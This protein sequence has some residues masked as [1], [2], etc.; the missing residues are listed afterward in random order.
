MS[1]TIKY[2]KLDPISHIHKRPDMYIGSLKPRAQMREW[3]AEKDRIVEKNSVVYSDGLLRIFIEA[4]SNSIDNVW[5]SRQAGLRP[6]KIRVTIDPLTGETSLWNDGLH[7][8]VEM[9][10][11][12]KIYNPELIFGHLLSGSNLDD[13]EARLSSGRNGLGIKLLNVFSTEFHVECA[14]PI[15]RKI[16]RQSWYDNMRR[17][18]PPTL[19]AYSL[20]TGYTCIRWK[21]DLEKFEMPNRVYDETILSL[22]EKYCM[23]AAM[24]TGIAVSFNE[25]KF[26]FKNFLDYVRLYASPPSESTEDVVSTDTD[27]DPDP[28]APPSP[29]PPA[30]PVLHA[31]SF[32]SDSDGTDNAYKTQYVILESPTQEYKEIG[33]I[34]GIHT[35]DGG[36]HLDSISSELWKSLIPRFTKS[37]AGSSVSAKDLKPHFMIFVNAWAPNPEFSSQ[38]KTKLL[39]PVIPVSLE[40]RYITQI[41][42]WPFVEKIND[43]L[44]SKELLSLK[45]TE[46]KTRGFK[47]IEGLDHAN[48][49]G[50]K[51]ARHCTLILCE[52]L[53]AKT[54]AVK[55]INVGW[56]G[57]KGRDY[58]GIY[59]LR[60]K[61]LN[62][63]NATVASI[64]NNRE[65]TDIIQ[66]LGLRYD[67]DYSTEE[68]LKTLQYGRVMILTDA[69][70][71]G[72]HICSLI[73]NL[74]HKL[75]P[76]LLRSIDHPPFLWLMM[77]PIARIF[78]S[79]SRQD[80]FYNDHDYRRALEDPSFSKQKIKYYKGLGTSSDAEIRETFG[81][82]VV[83]LVTDERCD[84][85]M[86]MAFHKMLSQDRKEW[87]ARY[88]PTAYTVPGSNYLISEYVNQEL[89]KFSIEDCSRSIPNLF[90]GL[91]KS[92]R[93][94]LYSVF[95]RRLNHE[96]K[97]MKVAQLAG[98]CA[99][100]SNYHHGEQCLFDTIVR[101]S[102]D[103]PGSNN[104]PYF[105]K[106]G[107]FGSLAYG[108]KDAANARYIF[109]KCAALTRLLFPEEDDALLTYTYDDGDR[110]EPDY[111][112]PILPTILGN[113]CTAGIGTGW[114]CSVPCHDFLQLADKV[115]EWLAL[116]E[117]AVNPLEMDLLPSYRGYKGKIEKLDKNK[118]QSTG[119]MEEVRQGRGAGKLVYKI[120]CLPIGTWT[121]KYKED[122]ETMM[123]QKKLKSIKNYSTPDTVHFELEAAED[124]KPTIENMKLRSPI[125]S[126]NMVL[127]TDSHRL[128]RYDALRDIFEVFCEARLA[129]YGVRKKARIQ[130]LE[131]QLVVEQNKKRF[132][133]EVDG[134]ILRVFRVRE[135]EILRQLVERDY[136]PD[137]RK[138][139]DANDHDEDKSNESTSTSASAYR[140]LLQ[141]P[142]KDVSL[143]KMEVLAQ[144][145]ARLED[146]LAR[147]REMTEKEM[148]R[149][150]LEQFT[151]AYKKV[152]ASSLTTTTTAPSST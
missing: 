87:L 100:T 85:T 99:E 8:P 7:I 46:K 21:P 49:A 20:K 69:D 126:T 62:V 29:S 117:E 61:L 133:E 76:S 120:T 84:N 9:H 66:A 53:S 82:K 72:H 147:A 54:Y 92:Q 31:V 122:L 125:S 112:L 127:F 88:D 17:M 136:A 36:V 131:I 28:D 13:T 86:D 18:E 132:L 14:D 95:K 44:R 27:T 140:Y 6:S 43:L 121:N 111:Y 93:K 106:D 3:I 102:Q 137:P 152:Y 60:G 89:I 38:S 148:W 119:I 128:Q 135:E 142:I 149:V 10:V 70:E 58:Y 47:R 71:D 77:T 81:Q 101:M 55:G 39:A 108:G 22:Y 19:R 2:Q 116:E 73:V 51:N 24:I 5:R 57:R 40:T 79:P 141:I 103:F 12:E 115:Q 105:E 146:D 16:Y 123:E 35:R 150:D 90:D 145:I 41:M 32:T 144:K 80:C 118:Y 97:S 67:A 45:K 63:R 30:S 113:G 94:I 52:G 124:F 65:I 37:G 138:E 11:E 1:K 23:D 110:V 109:T 104:V 4:L 129:L 96:G 114:S 139:T 83:S 50:G 15:Q 75:F 25:K 64:S 134:D 56:D 59:A 91:K 33:F 107:Q 48:L 74:F 130:R 68:A 78:Y 34:N 151:T 143:E 42:R 98:Y 26:H